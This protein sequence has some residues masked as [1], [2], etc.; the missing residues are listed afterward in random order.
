MAYKIDISEAQRV[1]L[2]ELVKA[3]GADKPDAALEYWVAMLEELP[4]EETEN[5]NVLHGFCL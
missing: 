1:A 4:K 3:S 2:L 5:P